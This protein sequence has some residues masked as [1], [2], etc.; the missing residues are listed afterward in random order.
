MLLFYN[1]NIRHL[2]KKMYNQNFY[3]YLYYRSPKMYLTNLIFKRF[4]FLKENIIDALNLYL[5]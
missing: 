1:E 2:L 3:L 4:M 5:E